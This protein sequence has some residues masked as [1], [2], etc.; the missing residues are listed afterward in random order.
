MK[1]YSH[2]EP[3]KPT[4]PYI[5]TRIPQDS[6]VIES[7]NPHFIW[8]KSNELDV[9]YD[10]AIFNPPKVSSADSHVI[11][12][13]YAIN[14]SYSY[15]EPIYYREALKTNEHI[16][17]KKLTAGINYRWSVRTRVN[18]RISPWSTY[19]CFVYAGLVIANSKNNFFPFKTKTPEYRKPINVALELAALN[20]D[21]VA[22]KKCIADGTDVNTKEGS[23]ALMYATLK[24]HSSIVRELLDR[25]AD[26]NSKNQAGLNSL[27]IAAETGRLDIVKELIARGAIIN[28]KTTH[29]Q[30]A[31]M[32]ASWKGHVS[33]VSELV[34]KGADVNAVDTYGGTALQAVFSGRYT[35]TS[36]YNRDALKEMQQRDVKVT[37]LVNGMDEEVKEKKMQ[38]DYET[39]KATQNYKDIR[40][41]LIAAGATH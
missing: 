23:V 3:I 25:G 4:I 40:E 30:T 34:V 15:G 2:L 41:I 33:I 8:S 32:L 12:D 5:C 13:S 22:V 10:F 18:D 6:T 7:I 21:L 31:L 20:G 28:E 38:A 39:Y 16:V 29:G 26:V 17:E 1:T 19:N 24:G 36:H 11:G 27:M 35:S 14:Y 9:T 37:A